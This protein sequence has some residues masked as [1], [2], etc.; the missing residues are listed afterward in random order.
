MA[1]VRLRNRIRAAGFAVADVSEYLDQR[2]TV[3]WVDLCAPSKQQLHTP[4]ASSACTSD[5]LGPHQ[6]PKLDRYATH[7][8][9]S[10]QAVRVDTDNGVLEA[11]EVDAFIHKR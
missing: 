10:C 2:D 11:T 8:F 1:L 3:V 7:L 6:R 9:L 4:P 5:A